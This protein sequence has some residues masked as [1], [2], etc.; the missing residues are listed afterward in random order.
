MTGAS[1]RR[2]HFVPALDG[3]RGVAVLL[4]VGLHY[5]QIWHKLRPGGAVPGG[6]V[7]VDIF[8]VLSG[9]LITSLLVGESA[10]TGRVRFRHF[11][12]RR[13][14]RLLPA[15]YVMLLAY[16]AYTQVVDGKLGDELKASLSVVFYAANFAQI[17][18]LKSMVKS[19]IGLT[20]SLA[21]EEQFYVLWPALLVF[22]VLRF[23]HTRATVLW[24]IGGGAVLSAAVRFAVWNFGSGFPAAYMRPDC[25]ADGLL[26]GA[27][28]AFL[29]RWDLLPTKW[30]THAAIVGAAFLV[31]VV[32]FVQ[33]RDFMFNGGFA[34]VSL[35]AAAIVLTVAN[36][37]PGFTRAMAFGPLRAVGRVS[38]GAYLWH[39]LGLRIA[40]HSVHTSNRLELLLAS[41]GLTTTFVVASWFLV[42]QPFLRLKRRVASPVLQ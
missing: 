38:Y 20:W 8:F 6:Y 18:F 1:P 11:Y 10:Q 16:L 35:A 36:G 13:A 34:L 12:A 27:L 4:V 2:F 40:L 7:G 31:Y 30:L 24:V 22:G 26:L 9:F 3:V 25:R 39:P 33:A 29:W 41:V 37:G 15:L 42:E 17:Y 5:G 21:I 23:A 19:P 14:L 28:C 32:F